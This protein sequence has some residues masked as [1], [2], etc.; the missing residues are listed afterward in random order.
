MLRYLTL[1]GIEGL[2]FPE[3]GGDGPSEVR[4]A[5]HYRINIIAFSETGEKYALSVFLY[6]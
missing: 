1:F 6:N 5:G 4:T 2:V 3:M